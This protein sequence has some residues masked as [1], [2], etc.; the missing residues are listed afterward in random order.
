MLNNP[1]LL[2]AALGAGL[3]L[4]TGCPAPDAVC[5]NGLVEAQEQCDDGNGVDDDGCESTCRP[6]PRIACGNG[7]REAQEGCDDG[8]QT[9]GDGCESTCERTPPPQEA[10]AGA[11]SL[12]QPEAGA[13]CKVIAAEGT[14]SGARLYMGVVLLD[15]KTLQG[16]QVLVDAQG[17]IQCAACDC[18]DKA[19]GAVRI[20]C[21]Q[22][23]ISPAL[24]NAHDHID[25]QKAPG[26]MGSERYEHRHD[27]RK[28]N[29]G[30]T[31]LP[32]GTTA[33]DDVVRWAELR[34]VMSGT[35]SIASTGGRG[36]LLRDLNYNGTPPA[37]NQEGLGEQDVNFDTF[38]LGDSDGQELVNSCAYRTAI[39]TPN[40]IP[41]LSAYLPHVSEG[42]E[43]SSRNEFRCLSG[44]G[45]GSQ[46][47]IVARTAIIHGIGV[48]ATEIGIMAERHTGL[49]WSPRSNVS[50]YG[51]TAMVTAYKQQGVNIALGT[52]WLQSGS[53]NMLRELQCADYLNAL[54]YSRSFTDEE[55]WRMATAS[56]ADLTDTWEKLGRIAPG[57]VADLAIFRLKAF[58]KSPHRAV[59]TANAEDVVLT[60]RGGKPL[61]GDQGV[62]AALTAGTTEACDAVDVCGSAK[63]ACVKS[64]LSGQSF[65]A[66]RTANANSYPLFFCG[67]QPTNEPT[68]AP[69]RTG[70]QPAASVNGST[71][72][73]SERSSTD[74]DGDGIPNTQDNCRIIFNPVRPLDNGKQADSDGDG[75]GDACDVCP[76]AANS[77]SC[78]AANPLDDDGDGISTLTDNCPML[79]NP[80]Q[81]DTDGDGKGNACDVCPSA[82][83]GN[84]ACAV[85]IYDLKKPVGGK[86]PFLNE[87]V[88]LQQALVT[89]VASSSYFLQVPADVLATGGVDFSAVFAFSSPT[90]L[91]AGDLIRVDSAVLKDYFGQAQLT[92]IVFTKLAEGQALP[93]F[94]SVTPAEVRT[95]GPRAEALESV[96]VELTNVYVTTQQPTPGAGDKTPTNEFVVD[97]AAGTD[98]EN[99]GVR[100]N[101]YVYQP[102]PMPLPAVGT[103][104]HA[105][106]GVLEWRNGNSK[107][108]PRDAG[109]LLALPRVSALS[110]AQATTAAGGRQVTFSAQLDN[111]APIE[112]TLAIQAQ[113]AELWDAPPTSVRIPAGARSA[114]FT[115]TTAATVP[116]TVTGGGVDVVLYGGTVEESRKSATVTLT[117]APLPVLVNLTPEGP[118]TFVQGLETELTVTLDIVAPSDTLVRLSVSPATGFGSVPETVLVLKGQKTAKF[119]FTAHPTADEVSGT[120]T[121]SLEAVSKSVSG[122]VVKPGLRV[123]SV[124]PASGVTLVNG[125]RIFTVTI[126]QVA[127]AEGITVQVRLEGAD[128]LGSINPESTI[129]ILEGKSSADVTFTARTVLGK[130]KI[131]AKVAANEVSADVAVITPVLISEFA[132]RGPTAASDDFVELYNPNDIDVPIGGW[133]LQYRTAS[134]TSTTVNYST[135]GT[136]PAGRVIKARGYFL[137][138]NDGYANSSSVTVTPDAKWGGTDLSASTGNV[139]FGTSEVKPDPTITTGVMDTM[140]YGTGRTLPEGSPTPS[141]ATGGSLERKAL[142]T[143]DATTMATGGADVLKGNGYDSNDNSKD[144]VVRT[145][146]DPQNASSPAEQP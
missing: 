108:E 128:G 78:T 138:S 99:A 26:A 68:C 137:M 13:T 83:P 102:S 145:T 93:A 1:R 46:N 39:A 55:L 129:Q 82:N 125:T 35:T 121:A 110:P 92:E 30:H 134:T 114:T 62:V 117:T 65:E 85:S 47:I 67:Q 52:D 81:R 37:A 72:Y 123:S 22:G 61:Y 80:D 144:F 2:L 126:N 64:E 51:E 60:V 57:K 24:I 113:P 19:A 111:P 58:A 84:M 56:A 27:W 41:A 10:C 120:I 31:T 73:S 7:I 16:G 25:Y 50:L 127:P 66:L 109:D 20:S 43:E 29:N 59:I 5:G 124:T 48:T 88:S 91:K 94:V 90:G 45:T 18:S 139:R 101:D 143:S 9:D 116:D 132:G 69:Q 118:H 23:V 36:G 33:G 71:V 15:G 44:Q 119:K 28:G 34:Q 54:H 14:A 70:T 21:P 107:V 140:A 49:I 12:P 131:F 87:R 115:L 96:L 136:I 106:R 17:V 6:S 63:A 4:L 38:P 100:V 89:A 104:Y 135:L 95:G 86:R 8:N 98:G 142:S 141:H 76:L 133:I 3:L 11:S 42:I 97:T 130:G 103:K 75:V 40:D 77:T 32:S 112:L 105:L 146:R 79:A 74:L 53:M 122:T